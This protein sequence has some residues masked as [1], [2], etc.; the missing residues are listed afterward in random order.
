MEA[1]YE[2]CE[3]EK[4][5]E[6]K[7]EEYFKMKAL[8]VQ[9]FAIS[10]EP[11]IRLIDKEASCEENYGAESLLKDWLRAKGDMTKMLAIIYQLERGY[12]LCL[13]KADEETI[14]L[15]VEGNENTH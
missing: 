14:V 15:E 6:A 11:Y 13:R 9:A 5:Y 12:A 2:K 1:Q 7:L 3:N 10:F 4:I 8:K